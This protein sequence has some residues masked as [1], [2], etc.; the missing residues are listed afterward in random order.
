MRHPEG[1]PADERLNGLAAGS[2]GRAESSA[3][4]SGLGAAVCAADPQ[5]PEFEVLREEV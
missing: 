1:R 4:G 3:G 2:G 5:S